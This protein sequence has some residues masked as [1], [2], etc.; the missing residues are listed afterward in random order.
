MKN[1]GC[2]CVLSNIKYTICSECLS[3]TYDDVCSRCG[4][5][6]K[7]NRKNEVN[8]LP[9]D[10]F[11]VERYL[12]GKVL[13]KQCDG[14]EYIAYDTEQKIFVIVK[15]FMPD[16]FCTRNQDSEIVN[17]NKDCEAKYKSILQDFK[18]IYITVSKLSKSTS[19]LTCHRVFELNNTV[20][21]IL[22]YV[23]GVSLE[24][25]L[26]DSLLSW[27]QFKKIFLPL[28]NSIS[29][30][31][32]NGLIHRGISPSTITVDQ[33][34]KIYL[35]Q[36]TVSDFRTV[37]TEFESTLYSGYC[38]PEQYSPT[39]WQGSWTDV[40]ALAGILY[41]YVTNKDP[42]NA[43][44]RT[45]AD[46]LK[47]ESVD[48]QPPICVVRAINEGML[49]C[50]ESRIQT[51]DDLIAKL[52]QQSENATAVFSSKVVLNKEKEFYNESNFTYTDEAC[53]T[54]ENTTQKYASS[55]KNK[56]NGLEAGEKATK[57]IIT[58]IFLI[59]VIIGTLGYGVA[60]FI[61]NSVFL[62]NENDPE[63]SDVSLS[64][65][66]TLSN[67]SSDQSSSDSHTVPKFL[68]QHIDIVSANKEYTKE[69]TF[70]VQEVYNE[71]YPVGIIFEQSPQFGSDASDV[72]DIILKVSKGS[73]EI[74]MPDLVGAKLDFAIA[75]LDALKIGCEVVYIQDTGYLPGVVA[76]TSVDTGEIVR[77]E[78]E[79]IKLFVRDASISSSQSNSSQ[80]APLPSPP[81]SSLMSDEEYYKQFQ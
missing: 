17:V 48:H 80:Q 52:L 45:K 64:S 2:I 49:S 47:V 58:G 81:S 32:S 1:R 50:V 41:R 20:Y 69:Y 67:P 42:Q 25:Y 34:D 35:T 14:F 61:F 38:A 55:G 4:F 74:V 70:E 40:Y 18:D 6:N 72:I 37:G 59:V 62:V 78:E 10:T 54:V 43:Q 19:L 76:F 71:E 44:Y 16:V 15:E 33:E 7:N 9:I 27:E 46:Y 3:L 29:N 28:C 36:I 51:V 24:Q 11:L 65:E 5:Q 26:N 30:L 77:K 63:S 57:K 21:A 22:K 56:K 68:K 12:I 23:Q 73:Q 39:A 31:H 53:S 75:T 13:T 60:T 66:S 8:A 79:F